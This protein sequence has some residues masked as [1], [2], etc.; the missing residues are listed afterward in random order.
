MIKQVETTQVEEASV[1]GAFKPQKIKYTLEHQ[2]NVLQRMMFDKDLFI[3][4]LLKSMKRL[5][6]KEGTK[7]WNWAKDQQYISFV[8]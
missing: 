4:E 3:K 1:K 5:G 2:K 8:A 7:L 6:P